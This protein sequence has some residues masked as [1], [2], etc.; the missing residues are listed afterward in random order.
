MGF[1]LSARGTVFSELSSV[2]DTLSKIEESL[3]EAKA[4]GLKRDGEVIRFRGSFMSKR[5]GGSV[6]TVISQGSIRVTEVQGQ[7]QV[8][9]DLHFLQNHLFRAA[10]SA[11][12]F[13]AIF[14]GVKTA[15][16]ATTVA[17][18]VLFWILLVTLDYLLATS[19]FPRFL[20]QKVSGSNS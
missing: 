4:R 11:A 12:A 15:D 3:R 14:F 18:G 8:A 19:G 17:A 13:G 20:M 6:L 2:P 7:V 16:P 10:V 1:P 9:Y 5:F